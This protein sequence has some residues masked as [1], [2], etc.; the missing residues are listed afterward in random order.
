M[1]CTACNLE[2]SEELKF[3]RECGQPLVRDLNEPATESLCCTRCGARLVRGEKNCQLCG[4]QVGAARQETVTGSCYNCGT[5][6]RSSWLYCKRCGLDRDR[7]LQLDVQAAAKASAASLAVTIEELPAAKRAQCVYCGATPSP[8]S[9]FCENC[10]MRLTAAINGAPPPPPSPPADNAVDPLATTLEEEPL[11]NVRD[12]G[13]GAIVNVEQVRKSSAAVNEAK[14]PTTKEAPALKSE[15][16]TRVVEKD[17]VTTELPPPDAEA[18]E[19]LR[20]LRESLSQEEM[21]RPPRPGRET[22]T[23]GGT[24]APNVSWVDTQRLPKRPRWVALV[25]M[26]GLAVLTFLLLTFWQA[27]RRPSRSAANQPT[28]IPRAT[29]AASPEQSPQ[30]TDPALPAGMVYI[31]GGVF[32]M[33]REDGDEYEKPQHLVEVKPFYLDRTE[34]TNERYKAF[35]EATGHRAPKHWRGKQPPAGEEKFPVVNIS[36]DDAVAFAAWEDKRLPTEEEWEFA[37]RGRDGRL[38]PWGSEWNPEFANTAESSTG[39]IVEVGR[40][41]GGASPFGVLDLCGNV[42]EWTASDLRSYLTQEVLAPNFK[43]IRG[44]AFDVRKEYATATYRGY[45][46]A[47]KV[48]PKTGFRGARSA[49]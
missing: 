24:T 39:K 38:Y 35:V 42:W 25:V 49:Q 2:Y 15:P 43:V 14:L 6:W 23:A 17:R 37:A 12:T 3:C 41:P 29:V 4:A 5:Y 19:Q 7:A 1:Y 9:H 8:H 40:Y 10:G 21:D 36:W 33:G 31:P 11:Y 48:Y 45:V 47:D 18:A 20:H 22:A 44:G 28:P 13:R 16:A 32:D 46:Q 27:S 34:V 30:K 26:A